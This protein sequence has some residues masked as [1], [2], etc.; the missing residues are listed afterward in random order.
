MKKVSFVPAGFEIA[1]K[2]AGMLV[3]LDEISVVVPQ[4]DLTHQIESY[5]NAGKTALPFARCSADVQFMTWIGLC[6]FNL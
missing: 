2:Q 1:A 6:T 3:F 4:A 5:T